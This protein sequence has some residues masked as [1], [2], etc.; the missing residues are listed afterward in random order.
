[1]ESI[2]VVSEEP[3]LAQTLGSELP[4]ITLRH[5][6]F[7]EAAEYMQAEKYRL[8]VIDEGGET[9]A[10]P[11]GEV[12]VIRLVRP[13]SL[14]EL[15]YTIRERLQGKS[16]ASRE[17]I[18]LS[19]GFRLAPSER[20]VRGEDGTVIPLTEKETELLQCLLVAD[21]ETIP[22]DML[23]KSV[24][25]YSDEITTH[26][27]ETH[28]YRLRGKLRQVTESLDI[29]SSEEGGYSLKRQAQ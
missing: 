22:R 19:P 20:L 8:V 18:Q 5:A 26:T 4:G 25:G 13:Q 1:M 24:W 23:L 7:G 9:G 6:R 27:L 12:S 28:I 2:L 29:S 21:G 17:E 15:L 16:A 3:A 14:S 11:G 10:I